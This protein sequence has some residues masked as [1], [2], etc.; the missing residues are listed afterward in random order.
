MKS[1]LWIRKS[2]EEGGGGT[3]H[4]GEDLGLRRKKVRRCRG[5]WGS[6]P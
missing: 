2:R 6:P 3:A 1:S 4:V 5:E